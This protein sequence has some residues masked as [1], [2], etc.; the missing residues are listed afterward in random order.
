MDYPKVSVSTGEQYLVYILPN[1]F[2]SFF[3]YN[4]YGHRNSARQF[5]ALILQFLKVH[6]LKQLLISYHF[7][8]LR[9]F[10]PLKITL[11][12]KFNGRKSRRIAK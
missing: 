5:V 4:F 10:L 7:A 11:K 12:V 9:D 8:I 2:L 6:P 1:Q 3:E